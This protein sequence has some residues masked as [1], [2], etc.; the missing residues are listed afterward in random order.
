MRRGI[1]LFVFLSVAL[2]VAAA[3]PRIPEGLARIDIFEVTGY[4]LV[5]GRYLTLEEAVDAL[6]V[7]P[8]AN[9]WD[10]LDPWEERLRRHPL[11]REARIRRK[12]PGTLVLEITERTPVAL[13]PTPTLEPVDEEGVLLPVDPTVHRLD[14][15]LLRLS[16]GGRTGAGDLRVD[17]EGRGVA[18]S[19]TLRWLAGVVVELTEADPHL[20]ARVSEI[21]LGERG[22]VTAHLASPAVD[23]LF[24]FPLSMRRLNQG[25]AALQDALARGGSPT[26]RA[27]VD[28]RYEDQVVVSFSPSKGR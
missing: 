17:P 6:G 1:R 11:V 3:A 2:I 13:L 14:L 27:T 20:M 18:D 4:Y 9:L 15:P 8:G 23:I 19:V 22:G 26:T 21:A 28:L 25:V 10:D 24:F 5:G 16:A 7:P 12:L